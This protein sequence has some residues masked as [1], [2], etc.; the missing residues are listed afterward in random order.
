[1]SASEISIK[2]YVEYLL[3]QFN[4]EIEFPLNTK[5]KLKVDKQMYDEL[6]VNDFTEDEIQEILDVHES[7]HLYNETAL[8]LLVYSL[9]NLGVGA[10]V[11]QITS[12]LTRYDSSFMSDLSEED[13]VYLERCIRDFTKD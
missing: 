3:R 7:H 11:R 5:S 9:I 8:K 10:T 13:Q 2:F 12:Y 6:Y 1:M 4:H